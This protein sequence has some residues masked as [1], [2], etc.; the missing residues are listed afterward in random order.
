M[1]TNLTEVLFVSMRM[2]TLG[3]FRLCV[4]RPLKHTG[5]I[6]P[7]EMMNI[8][9]GLSFHSSCSFAVMPL[10]NSMFGLAVF[11]LTEFMMRFI[12]M[13]SVFSVCVQALLPK[14]SV[15]TCSCE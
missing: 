13:I 5:N 1:L 10:T 2:L 4:R 11:Y 3:R 7:I 8:Q 14:S 12:I 6:Y 15:F 9:A